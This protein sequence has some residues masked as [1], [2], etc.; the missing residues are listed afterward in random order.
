MKY[1]VLVLGL[2]ISVTAAHGAP[3][4]FIVRLNA[5]GTLDSALDQDGA[6]QMCAGTDAQCSI[7]DLDFDA[8]NGRIV[9]VG[10]RRLSATAN[11]SL[12]T[13]SIGRTGFNSLTWS[14]GVCLE[15]V[16]SLKGI[17]VKTGPFGTVFALG[18][19]TGSDNDVSYF[20][21]KY[22][23]NPDCLP[24]EAFPVLVSPVLPDFN[25]IPVDLAGSTPS[26]KEIY[27][28]GPQH[29]EP[30]RGIQVI[31]ES[32]VHSYRADGSVN[33][34][35]GGGRLTYFTEDDKPELISTATVIDANHTLRVAGER[36]GGFSGIIPLNGG[37]PSVLVGPLNAFQTWKAS[38]PVGGAST[39][40]LLAGSDEHS[41]IAVS[42]QGATEWLSRVNFRS[43]EREVARF[44]AVTRDGK[45]L[46][47]GDGTNPVSPS[48]ITRTVVIARFNANGRLDTTFDGDGKLLLNIS[49]EGGP[50]S[51]SG[52]LVIDENNDYYIAVN[53]S[54]SGPCRVTVR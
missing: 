15:D 29:T 44:I 7:A 3:V 31:Q 16:R 22:Y 39:D 12:W 32:F 30:R 53:G 49:G 5:N 34:A 26:H 8:A 11:D 33:T 9:L 43:Q 28:V 36:A 27:V 35:F 51:S 14:G 40:V 21:T 42:R 46:V 2:L 45:I 50:S 10:T 20:L 17:A 13:R 54:C 48:R 18:K 23:D 6:M 19:F 4:A 1:W 24:H 37:R 41:R 47:V 38:A 52:G 25:L